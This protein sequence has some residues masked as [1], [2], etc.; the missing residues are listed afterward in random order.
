LDAQEKLHLAGCHHVRCD[1]HHDHHD[2]HH[3]R[4]LRKRQG[5]NDE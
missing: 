4:R 3:G 1:D 2:H 5:R